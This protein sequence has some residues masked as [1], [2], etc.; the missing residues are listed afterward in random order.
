VCTLL[1]SALLAAF[2]VLMVS[3]PWAVVAGVFVASVVFAIVLHVM[4]MPL[5][6]RLRLS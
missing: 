1:V 2:G 6:S 5:F 3:L 4:K